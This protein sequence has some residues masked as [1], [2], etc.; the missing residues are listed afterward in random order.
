MLIKGTF[1]KLCMQN[2]EWQGGKSVGCVRHHK[3]TGSSCYS[4]FQRTDQ[5]QLFPNT[6]ISLV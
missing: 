3:W 5:L 6:G 2:K 1:W 4:V